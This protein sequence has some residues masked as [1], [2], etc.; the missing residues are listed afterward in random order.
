[1]CFFGSSPKQPTPAPPPTIA[2]A[3][4]PTADLT[5]PQETSQQRT[6]RMA[7]LRYGLL[8]TIRTSARGVAGTG[9]DLTSQ[10]QQ[11]KKTTL[12]S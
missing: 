1:M 7:A 6:R 8:S 9:A 5:N 10:N 11:G 12:G 2:P 4:S 3:P